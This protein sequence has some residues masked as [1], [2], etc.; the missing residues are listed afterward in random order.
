MVICPSV[1]GRYGAAA[2]IACF[3]SY[4]AAPGGGV[5]RPC[6]CTP[7]C[8]YKTS[9]PIQYPVEK[10]AAACLY[11]SARLNKIDLA[12]DAHIPGGKSFQEAFSISQ[13]ELDGEHW[14]FLATYLQLHD[15]SSTHHGN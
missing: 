1:A 15:L 11:H 3:I 9:L 2:L 7:P 8:S 5:S 4:L 14:P 13:A 10:L 12:K 6:S